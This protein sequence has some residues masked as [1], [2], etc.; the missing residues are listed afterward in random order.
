MAKL[1]VETQHDEILFWGK[2]EGVV[3]DYHIALGLNYA[4]SPIFPTKT[5]YWCSSRNYNFASLPSINAKVAEKVAAINTQFTGEYDTILGTQ[6]GET[7]TIVLEDEE[8]MPLTI[9][10]KN[11][12]ELDRLSHTVQR[13]EEECH[14]IP[15]GS[16]KLTPIQEARPNEAFTGLCK[17]TAFDAAKYLHF[18]PPHTKEKHEQMDRDDSI[19]TG[20]WLDSIT[21]DPIKGAWTIH[22]DVTGSVAQV[23]NLVW[24]GYS[25][26][27]KIGTGI[28]ASF[29]IGNGKMNSDLAFML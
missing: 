19:F 6:E 1:K 8:E 20:D 12:T 27:H 2:I 4:G 21:T 14:V 3:K 25:A 18:T 13:I 29:Y 17:E 11:I 22:P 5:F 15:E 16:L 9:K 7:K 24:P 10:P 28:H 26:Y 23:R